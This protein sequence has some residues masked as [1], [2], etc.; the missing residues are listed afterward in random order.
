[1]SVRFRTKTLDV[2]DVIVTVRHPHG[3]VDVPLESWIESG[4]GERPL[5]APVAARHGRTG[6]RLPLSVVAL[7]YRNI[8]LSRLLIALRLIP[9]PWSQPPN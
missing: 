2:A 9:D 4:P 1:M 7:R 3:D 6:A 5:V 8:R